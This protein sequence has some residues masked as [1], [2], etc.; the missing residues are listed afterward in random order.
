MSSGHHGRYLWTDSFGVV[1]FLTLYKETANP[2]YLRLERS[3]IHTVHDTLGRTRDLSTLLPNATATH[4]LLGGLRI[5]KESATGL[6]AN[7]QYFH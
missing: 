3:L 2:D 4:P 5:G 7:G 1:G 6:D